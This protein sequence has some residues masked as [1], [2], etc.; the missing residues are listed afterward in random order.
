[1]VK[2][3]VFGAGTAGS[4]PAYPVFS[5]YG[6]SS[7]KGFPFR[8]LFCRVLCSI[9]HLYLAFSCFAMQYLNIWRYLMGIFDD[10]L[11]FMDYHLLLDIIDYDEDEESDADNAEESD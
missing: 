1:V 11:D 5:N 8:C 6:L 7:I 9:I 2:A 4:I 3:L 10:D